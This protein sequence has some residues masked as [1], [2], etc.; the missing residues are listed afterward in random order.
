MS[1][2]GVLIS[3][4]YKLGLELQEAVRARDFIHNKLEKVKILIA[5]G[6]DINFQ[7][8]SDNVSQHV[9]CSMLCQMIPKGDPI[10]LSAASAIYS[11][12][13]LEYLVSVGVEIDR[14][15]NVTD[16][17]A[18]ELVAFDSCAVWYNRLALRMCFRKI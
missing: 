14:P 6:A 7:E 18:I 4:S 10:I 3:K 12:P 15:N 2:S 13:L 17:I 5:S 11:A 1:E 9:I 16:S 8:N